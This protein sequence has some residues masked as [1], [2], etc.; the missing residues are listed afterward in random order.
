MRSVA[1]PREQPWRF[2][3]FFLWQGSSVPPRASPA[4]RHAP[5]EAGCFS[6]LPY[7]LGYA[8]SMRCLALGHF[9]RLWSGHPLRAPARGA[10]LCLLRGQRQAPPEPAELPASPRQTWIK[11]LLPLGLHQYLL[12]QQAPRASAP[13]GLCFQLPA[14]A[15]AAPGPAAWAARPLRLPQALLLHCIFDRSSFSSQEASANAWLAHWA[16]FF[17]TK[18]SRG[19]APAKAA[20]LAAPGAQGPARPQQRGSRQAGAL[21]WAGG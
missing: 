4:F 20:A 1:P 8:S 10:C 6:L 13:A 11:P 5:P 17:A 15:G 19:S 3:S 18:S 14:A 2:P 21:C 9:W 7:R 16:H 12:F